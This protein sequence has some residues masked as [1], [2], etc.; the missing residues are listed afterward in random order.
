M[1][2]FAKLTVSPSLTLSAVPPFTLKFKPLSAVA[3]AVLAVV[4]AV[5]AVVLAVFAVF[6]AVVTFAFVVNN[7]PP[8]TASFEPDAMLPSATPVITLL[9][10]LIPDASTLGPPVIVKPVLSNLLL[11]V[12]TE[13][14]VGVSE[15]ETLIWFAVT[16][17]EIFLLSPIT[18]TV[19][20]NF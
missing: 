5:F 16:A 10:A 1:V 3:C 2:P 6:C 14:N 13:V 11:P 9:P 7:C 15:I 12:V 18:A 8:F 4:S 20:P 17:V 19:E